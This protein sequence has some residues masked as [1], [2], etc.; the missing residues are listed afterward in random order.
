MQPLFCWAVARHVTCMLVA[1]LQLEE[2]RDEFYLRIPM[3]FI[4]GVGAR[5]Q[6]V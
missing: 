4:S 1:S 2:Q 3:T 5:G 6:V